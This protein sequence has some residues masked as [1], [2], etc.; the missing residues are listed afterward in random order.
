MLRGLPPLSAWSAA[1]IGAIV[2]FGGTIA[3]VV[4]AMRQLGAS[5]A[6]TGSAVTALCLGIAVAGAALSLRLRIPVVLAWS[7]PGAALLAAS[8]PGLTWAEA[9]G[10]FAAAALMTI[11]TALVPALARAAARI[12]PAIASALLAGILLPFCLRLFQLGSQDPLLVVLLVAVFVTT[13][14]RLPLHALM[15]TL[16]AGI[17]LT[18]SRGDIAALPPGTTFGALLP[19]WPAVNM[20]ATLSM[21]LPL[22]LVTL[23]SQNIPGLVVL[24]NAG[25][26]VKPRTLLL[27]G[28]LAWLAAAPFGAHGV[29]LAAITAAICTHDTAHPDAGR[30]WQVGLLYAGFY[31]LLAI[32]APLL[33]RLFL[34]LPV[35]VI[36]ALTGIALI[37]AL[38]GALEGMLT[39]RKD[40]DPALV[41]FLATGSGLALFGFGSALWGLAAG[42]AA[43][44][45]TRALSQRR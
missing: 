36:G 35:G 33:V 8:A 25:Y 13:R 17:T 40:R 7:T 34:A 18:L 16:A 9:T 23:I 30:R 21:A 41:T 15:L 3:L 32:F 12:P 26:A 10:V 29:N 20:S 42:F 38:L 24:Q 27:G 4:E 44:G 45:V 1:L 37:P 28:G 14:Q 43:L 11:A 39:V 19:V 2:G 5:V 6:E 31:L 22:F